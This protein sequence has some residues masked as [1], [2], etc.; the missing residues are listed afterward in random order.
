MILKG[1]YTNATIFSETVESSA[2]DQIRNIINQPFMANVKVRIMPD[3]HAGTGICVGYTATKNKFIVPNFIG[4][5]IGCGVLSQH[6]KVKSIDF[7]AFDKYVREHIPHGMKNNVHFQ[8]K[9]ID[10]GVACTQGAIP[11]FKN[12]VQRVAEKVYSE[13]GGA[14]KAFCQLGSLGGGNH[15]I[16]INQDSEGDYWLTIHSGSRN[17]GLSVANYHQKIAKADNGLFPKVSGMEYLTGD[18]AINYLKDAEVAQ[19]FAKVN[20]YVILNRLI[21]FFEDPIAVKSIQQVHTIHNYIDFSN[22]IVR[23]GAVA[24]PKDGWLLIPMSMKDGILLCKGKGNEEWNYSAPHGAGRLMSRSKAK[25]NLDLAE[26]QRQMAEA[27]VW[28]SCVGKDT[29]DESPMAYKPPEDIKN[30]IED[31]VNIIDHWKEVYNFKAS[32]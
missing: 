27:G 26:Y 14:D 18:A 16:A 29:I 28:T 13:S 6:L 15:F 22:G 32:E 9:E 31:T 12:G 11:N 8:S 17:L 1:E 30:A 21:A 5:D 23:K 10:S 19:W 2:L 7:A 25:Q 20:R 24:A 3:V 4:V